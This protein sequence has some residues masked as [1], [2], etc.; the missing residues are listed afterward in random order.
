MPQSRS[1]SRRPTH[2]GHRL[3]DSTS[4]AAREAG[5][6]MLKKC[7]RL[8]ASCKLTAIELCQLYHLAKCA[9]ALGGHV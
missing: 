3:H 8:Y 2:P 9:K 1:R 6:D 7:L 4:L 5:S